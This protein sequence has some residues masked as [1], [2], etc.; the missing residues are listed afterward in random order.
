MRR[1]LALLSSV[2]MFLALST[3]APQAAVSKEHQQMM[4]DI[5]MIQQQ[6]QALQ[7]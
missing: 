2:A 6:N 4:A 1:Q 7:A 3:A 5:R